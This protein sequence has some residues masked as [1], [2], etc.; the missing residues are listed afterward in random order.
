MAPPAVPTSRRAVVVVAV[1]GSSGQGGRPA[2]EAADRKARAV[3]EA[4]TAA[5]IFFNEGEGE[6]GRV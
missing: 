1:D 2:E 4:A 6:V 3:M 5:G